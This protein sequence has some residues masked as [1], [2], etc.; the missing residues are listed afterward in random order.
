MPRAT[1]GLLVVLAFA[2]LVA[3]GHGASVAH[4]ASAWGGLFRTRDAGATWLPVNPASF[5]SGA[6]AVGVSPV[7]PHHLLLATDTG[8]SR[9]RHG[10]RDWVLEAQRM[11]I[12]HIFALAL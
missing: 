1:G 4:D 10:R 2:V 8:L 9:S 3:L 12:G 6:L 5:V 7:D 11:L